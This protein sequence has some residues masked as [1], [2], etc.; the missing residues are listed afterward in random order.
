MV[1]FFTME[2]AKAKQKR[3]AYHPYVIPALSK[4]PWRPFYPAHAKALESWMTLNTSR[5]KPS[6]SGLNFQAFI[7]YNLRFLLA[8]DLA[9]FWAPFGDIAAQFAH[10]GLIFNMAVVENG[11]IATTYAKQFTEKASH[12]ARQRTAAVDWASFLPG[13]D[14]VIKKNVLRELGHTSLTK[15]PTK[16]QH[17]PK[18]DPPSRTYDKGGV[19]GGKD[20]K[21]KK[22]GGATST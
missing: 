3:S 11:A 4:D 17:P 10:L 16:K 2:I 6:P 7:F 15:Q 14:G 8:G 22:K 18:R 1:N 19:K 12:L 20:Q 13:E 9:G 5:K 21:G